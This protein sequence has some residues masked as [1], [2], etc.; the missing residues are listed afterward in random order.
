MN[1]FIFKG[2]IINSIKTLNV[3]KSV[4]DRT[5][6]SKEAH[7]QPR[8]AFIPIFDFKFDKGVASV[9]TDATFRALDGKST[10]GFVI[11]FYGTFVHAGSM[12]GPNVSTAKEAR[13]EQFFLQ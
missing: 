5:R 3:A 12:E 8:K 7:D 10:F 6:T 13:R 2:H 1:D 11:W 4:F 9:C